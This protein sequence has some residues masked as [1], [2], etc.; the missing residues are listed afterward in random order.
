MQVTL[1]VR[2]PKKPEKRVV[3]ESDVVIGRGKNCNLQ[4]L[5]SDVS[6]QHCRLV[7]GESA[8]AV[9]DLGSG[10]GTLI[11]GQKTEPNVEA[12]LISGDIVRIGPLVIKVDFP[13]VPAPTD[14]PAPPEPAAI[15]STASP[16]AIE[17]EEAIP[18]DAVVEEVAAEAEIAGAD[19]A[20]AFPTVETSSAEE[21]MLEPLGDDELVG[22]DGLIADEFPEAEPAEIESAED[23]AEEISAT[24]K[25][26]GKMKSL[27]GMFGKKKSKTSPTDSDPQPTDAEV[28]EDEPAQ[29]Q[30]LVDEAADVDEETVVFER[31]NAFTSEEDVMEMLADDDEFLDEDEEEAVDPGFADFLNQVDQPPS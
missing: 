30:L 17:E 19:P 9:C 12:P 31:E 26:S 21:E 7:I 20:D 24:E 10:N 22:D 25:S 4:V 5:S 28:N 29:E 6:R 8:V 14:I 13:S 15:S 2:A 3:V 18:E 23:I 11:N 16:T 27:F 1:H